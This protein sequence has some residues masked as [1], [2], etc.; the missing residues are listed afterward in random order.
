MNTNS[1]PLVMISWD[2]KGD[3]LPC[4]LIDAA[5]A[6]NILLVDYSGQSTDNSS[7]KFKGLSACLLSR[8]TQCKGDLFQVVGDYIEKNS[9]SPEYIGMLDDDIVIS[10]SDI[11]KSL[12]IARVKRLDIF[13]PTLTH[14]SEF[15]HRWMLQQPHRA[16]REVDWVEVMM[17]FYNVDIFMAARP[18]FVNFVTSWGF[19][20]YL[21]PMIQRILN[22]SRC[23]L[24]DAVSASHFRPVTSQLMVYRNGLTAAQE[25]EKMKSICINYIECYYSDWIKTEWFE[26]IYIRKNTYTRTQKY[27]YRLGRPI[28]QWLER[29]A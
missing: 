21:F 25:M 2:G 10:I 13:S 17:P 12:H 15:S 20:K 24:I 16:V 29:S 1:H 19:D 23:G 3:Y 14:D 9:L 4:V 5:P 6:F 7:I 28:K 18:F 8:I 27:I 22:K 26:K 11:N